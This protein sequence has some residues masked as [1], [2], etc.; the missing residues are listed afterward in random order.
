MS[1]S[2]KISLLWVL[3]WIPICIVSYLYKGWGDLLIPLYAFV[4]FV[5]SFFDPVQRAEMKKPVSGWVLILALSIPAI[6]LTRGEII[7]FGNPL[8]FV[9]INITGVALIAG[10]AFM[11]DKPTAQRQDISKDL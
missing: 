5:G 4:C 6:L 1:G 11:R 2:Q 8:L 9:A 3:P 10:L 7:S